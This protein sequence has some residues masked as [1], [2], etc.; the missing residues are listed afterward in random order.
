MLET[1][2]KILTRFATIKIYL[3]NFD[4]SGCKSMFAVGIMVSGTSEIE[5]DSLSICS[6][7]TL[8]KIAR[9]LIF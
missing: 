9:V 1:L 4:M 8:F 6:E 5:S 2:W 7:T 3:P